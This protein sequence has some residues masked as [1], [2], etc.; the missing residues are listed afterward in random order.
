MNYKKISAIIVTEFENYL[1]I[2]NEKI[3]ENQGIRGY[4]TLLAKGA[5]CQPSYL[6]QVFAGTVHLTPDH[7]AG[8]A[9]FWNFSVIDSEYFTSLVNKARASTPA[10]K[11]L[12]GN[13]L[14]ELRIKSAR[15]EDKI[16][17]PRID[18]HREQALYYS[19]WMYSAVHMIVSIA[20]YQTES[21]ISERLSLPV[22]VVSECLNSLE[23]M[24][25]VGKREDTKSAWII[26]QWALHNPKDHPVSWL[27]HANWRHRALMDLQLGESDSIHY[28]SLY[29]LSKSDLIKLT[30]MTSRFIQNTRE[31]IG[32]SN[33]EQLVSFSIDLFQ[34]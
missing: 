26:K 4:R 17:D 33:E 14:Q 28:T 20:G 19:H 29:T 21:A 31:L 9:V 16:D 1:E 11:E 6:S 8:L 13:R 12:I 3:N 23:L 22:S 18:S 24:G 32:P 2:I 25:L 34:V 7:A 10:L 15:V 27:H 30:G 5:G